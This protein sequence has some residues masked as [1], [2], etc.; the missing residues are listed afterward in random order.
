MALVLQVVDALPTCAQHCEPGGVPAALLS[1]LGV[2]LPSFQQK[3]ER[4]PHPCPASP[5]EKAL[6]CHCPASATGK[7]RWGAGGLLRKR[8]R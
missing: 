4:S 2:G 1:R 5:R 8:F 3:K 7:R 6:P